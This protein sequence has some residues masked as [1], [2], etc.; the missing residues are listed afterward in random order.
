MNTQSSNS[1]FGSKKTIIEDIVLP[2][3]WKNLSTKEQKEWIKAYFMP[4]EKIPEPLLQHD[5]KVEK[6][7]IRLKSGAKVKFYTEKVSISKSNPNLVRELEGWIGNWLV[8]VF[9][10]KSFPH[11]KYIGVAN[12]NRSKWIAQELSS[13]ICNQL[14]AIILKIRWKY[15]FF[16]G[17]KWKNQRKNGVSPLSLKDSNTVRVTP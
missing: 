3:N 17:K 7:I 6:G 15:G 4:K 8:T 9:H 14:Y 12:P 1:K 10:D 2:R 5:D 11:V 13:E 16:K